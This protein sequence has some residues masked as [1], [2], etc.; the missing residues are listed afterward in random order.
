MDFIKDQEELYDRTNEHFKDKAGKKCLW[1]MFA[2]CL[3]KYARFGSDS[4]GLA[5][6]N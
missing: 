6:A 1:E 5:T 4:K 2:S 3:P